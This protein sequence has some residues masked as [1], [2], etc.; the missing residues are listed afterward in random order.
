MVHACAVELQYLDF[1]FSDEE[2]GR[3]SFDAMASVLSGRAPAVLAEIATVLRWATD[4]FGAVGPSEEDGEW[5][6][7]VGGIIEPGTPMKVTFDEAS[8]EV[9]LAPV[10]GWAR[11]TFTLTL[12]GSAAFCEAL[13]ERFELG[14]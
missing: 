9:C 11:A 7:E 13:R 12:T 4:T 2:T 6:Y 5:A 8:G 1:D 14:N 10:R 3:G